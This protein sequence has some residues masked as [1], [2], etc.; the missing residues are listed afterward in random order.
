MSRA[1][2]RYNKIIMPSQMLQLFLCTLGAFI[3]PDF[4]GNFFLILNQIVRDSPELR[5]PHLEVNRMP[6]KN[7]NELV[8]NTV[9]T[10]RFVSLWSWPS[11]H[12]QQETCTDRC[13]SCVM[14][15]M[16]HGKIILYDLNIISFGEIKYCDDYSLYP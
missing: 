15:R 16:A 12:C 9:S 10:K 1:D 14:I 13:Q 2:H 11:V 6:L 5:F 3:S 8:N 4:A 7:L